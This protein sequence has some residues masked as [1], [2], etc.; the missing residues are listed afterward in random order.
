MQPRDPTN[1]C[2]FRPPGSTSS[3]SLREGERHGYSIM[4]EVA[5]RTESKLRLGPGTLYAALKRL[6]GEG[7]VKEWMTIRRRASAAAFTASPLRTASGLAEMDAW[8]GRP[9][10]QGAAGRGMTHALR[11]ALS[12]APEALPGGLPPRTTRRRWR[13]HSGEQCRTRGA[14][15]AW[16]ET[17]PDLT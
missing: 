17:I 4:Q 8:P 12:L 6:A 10:G 5:A 14:V 1:C 13:S 15:R 9:A 3:S 2:R 16:A 7:L 11:T